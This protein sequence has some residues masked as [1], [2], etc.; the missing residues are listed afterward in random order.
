MRFPF[1][2]VIPVEKPIGVTSR[3]VVDVVGRAL[4]MRAVGHAGTLDPLA[5]GVVVVCVGSATKL[6]DYIHQLPKHY[7]ALFLLGRSSP[8]D[9]CETPIEEEDNPVRPTSEAIE[10]AADSFRGEFLQ[11]PCDYS[12]VH[13]DGKRAY[14]LAR[15]GHTFEAESKRVCIDRLEITGYQWPQLSMELVCSSGTY[16]RAIGRDLAESLGTRAVMQSLARTAVGRFTRGIPLDAIDSATAASHLL[17]A[18][19]AVEHL[20]VVSLDADTL[21]LAVRGGLI[22]LPHAAADAIAAVDSTSLLVGILKRH[23]SGEF[24][25]RPNFL[26]E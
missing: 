24:R 12:A 2:G 26:G 11:R 18:L 22:C 4:S 5:S 17:P 23:E 7:T 13:I 10:S 25:L 1:T 3:R 9:D 21:G 15:S 19:A 16:V 8:S 6:V 14:R 20:P